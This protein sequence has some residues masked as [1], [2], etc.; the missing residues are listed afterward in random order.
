[1]VDDEGEFQGQ[2]IKVQLKATDSAD[3]PPQL[4]MLSDHLNY[5][6]NI[7]S[8]QLA[9]W[10]TPPAACSARSNSDTP[11]VVMAALAA[12]DAC[13]R[14]RMSQTVVGGQKGVE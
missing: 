5:G 13:R 8:G 10:R 14:R 9:C 2:I 6:Q 12:G 1:M 4:Q 11:L 3:D 7:R